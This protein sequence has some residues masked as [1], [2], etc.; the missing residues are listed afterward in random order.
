[1]MAG[2]RIGAVARAA[3]V[4][5]QTVRYYER[6]GLLP[7]PP[8]TPSGYRIYSPDA[9]ARLQFIKQAQAVGFSL[10]EVREILRL[11]YNG[12][13]PCE[14]VRGMLEEKLARVEQEM[15]ALT[16]FRRELRRTLARARKL[17]H[18]SHRASAI[19]PIIEI[20]TTDKPRG[21]KR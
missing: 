16:R 2:A 1:M 7:R 14:C 19:C 11:K 6:A 18:V 21:D 12:R 5:V 13:S 8:R 15:A 4:S 10:E 17:P 9:A 20:S 3:G